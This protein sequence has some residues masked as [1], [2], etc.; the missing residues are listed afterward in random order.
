[1]PNVWIFEVTQV[2]EFLKKEGKAQVSECSVL[3]SMLR[4]VSDPNKFKTILNWCPWFIGYEIE[5][6]QV[7]LNRV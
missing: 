1:M 3:F 6:K 4:V 2:L 7:S 5:C